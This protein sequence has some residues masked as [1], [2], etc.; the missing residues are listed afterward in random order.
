[1]VVLPGHLAAVAVEHDERGST[2]PA[3]TARLAER[4]GRDVARLDGR[5]EHRHSST[6]R[7]PSES[8]RRARDAPAW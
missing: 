8:R 5:G 6:M 4:V 7:P 1:M 2:P 3:L